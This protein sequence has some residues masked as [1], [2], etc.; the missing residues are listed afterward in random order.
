MPPLCSMAGV[1][2]VT[3]IDND[4]GEVISFFPKIIT[5]YE[6]SANEVPAGFFNFMCVH[7]IFVLKVGNM[8]MKKTSN[9]T[10]FKEYSHGQY[11]FYNRN[12]FPLLNLCST[13][14]IIAA[15]KFM[16]T[17]KPFF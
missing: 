1:L 2:T 8:L 13:T 4:E 15:A 3:V 14:T 11:I 6:N 12:Q 9:I 10:A 16:Q 7:V 17:V 5:L